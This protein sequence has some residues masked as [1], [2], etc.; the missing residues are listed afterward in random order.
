MPSEPDICI[1]LW[2]KRQHSSTTGASSLASGSCKIANRLEGFHKTSVEKIL[3]PPN[4]TC[5]LVLRRCTW[6]VLALVLWSAQAHSPCPDVRQSAWKA[7]VEA[8]EQTAWNKTTSTTPAATTTTTRTRART[9]RTHGVV[10]CK[11]FS[12]N[13]QGRNPKDHSIVHVF[14]KKNSTKNT[15]R[16]SESEFSVVCSRGKSHSASKRRNALSLGHPVA[17]TLLL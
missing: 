16:V 3:S 7:G 17:P 14:I 13:T 1:T 9:T 11:Y 12:T 5:H 4:K 15:M 10:F 6:M 8:R 2:R